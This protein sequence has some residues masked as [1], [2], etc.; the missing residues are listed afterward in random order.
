M[1]LLSVSRS[2]HLFW[3][4]LGEVSSQ[5]D[6][7]SLTLPSLLLLLA[8]FLPSL[9]LSRPS[10]LRSGPSPPSLRP[11]SRS[12]LLS[13]SLSSTPCVSAL[14]SCHLLPPSVSSL[15]SLLSTRRPLFLLNKLSRPSISSQISSFDSRPS[16]SPNPRS[17]RNPSECS[18][19]SFPPDVSPSRR[20]LSSLLVSFSS[21]LPILALGHELIFALFSSRL[22]HLLLRSQDLHVPLQDSHLHPLQLEHQ[23]RGR[24]SL[25][26]ARWNSL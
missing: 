3:R 21:S 12:F 6:S 9:Q 20:R 16:S 11:S 26:H 2:I 25:H 13:S 23:S 5:K 22:S 15:A 1:S 10:L 8:A 14:S 4:E 17:K 24:Q 18:S 19:V 7:R